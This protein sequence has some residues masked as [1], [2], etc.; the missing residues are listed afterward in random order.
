[1]LVGSDVDAMSCTF[2]EDVVQLATGGCAIVMRCWADEDDPDV[3]EEL[4]RSGTTPLPRGT[5]EV[6]EPYPGMVKMVLERDCKVTSRTFRVGDVVRH[7]YRAMPHAIRQAGVVTKVATRGRSKAVLTGVEEEEWVDATLLAGEGRIFKGDYVAQAGWIGVVQSVGQGAWVEGTGEPPFVTFDTGS[8]LT[9]GELPPFPPAGPPNFII[10][11]PTPVLD[12]ARAALLDARREYVAS[13]AA[14]VLDVQTLVVAINWLCFNQLS[15]SSSTSHARPPRY[16][17]QLDQLQLVRSS[18][19]ELTTVCDKVL[20][21]TGDKE[22]RVV[23]EAETKVSVVWQD[24]SSDVGVPSIH[25]EH[26]ILDEDVD[27]FPGDVGMFSSAGEEGR[28]GV[29]QAMNAKQRTVVLRFLGTDEVETVSALEF[30]P[31]G[32]PPGTYGLRRGDTVLVT[33][34]DQPDALLAVPSLGESE[35]LT[36]QFPSSAELHAAVRPRPFEPV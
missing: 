27:V 19:D 31:H 34:E 8:L 1:M 25:F 2:P 5:L 29:A 17:T 36:G 4:Q 23:I 14:C 32:P 35:V 28:P 26:A 12:P 21:K 13:T 30:D 18:A 11:L 6:L 3:V 16:C 33:A 7:C 20:H 24:G 15:P 9:V 10:R 22:V